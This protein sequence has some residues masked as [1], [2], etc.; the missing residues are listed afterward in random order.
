[1]RR[2]FGVLVALSATLLFVLFASSG[3]AS[4]ATPSDTTIIT[5]APDMP[6]DFLSI[7]PDFSE[8][9]LAQLPRSGV[10]AETF[11]IGFLIFG[12]LTVVLA[13]AMLWIHSRRQTAKV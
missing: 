9:E 12:I 2:A 13:V 5:I 3:E 4:T 1:M 8:E 7:Y 10:A 6:D 11:I